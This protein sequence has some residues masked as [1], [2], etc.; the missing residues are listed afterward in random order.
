[1]NRNAAHTRA[2]AT[3]ARRVAETSAERIAVA[4]QHEAE[5]RC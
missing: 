3:D 4:A 5:T 2:D 1:M